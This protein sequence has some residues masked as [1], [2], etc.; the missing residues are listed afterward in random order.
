M[1]LGLDGTLTDTRLYDPADS[2]RDQGRHGLLELHAA[3]G[4]RL[5]LGLP[6]LGAGEQ[7]VEGAHDGGRVLLEVVHD[8]VRAGIERVG[9][10]R[11]AGGGVDG[12]DGAHGGPRDVVHVV[13]GRVGVGTGGV[14]RVGVLHGDLGELG[15]VPRRH[16]LLHELHVLGHD[17]GDALLEEIGRRHRLLHARRRADALLGGRGDEH[18]RPHLG[19]VRR[20]GHLHGLGVEAVGL[21]PHLPRHVPAEQAAAGGAAAL[22]RDQGEL[23]GRVG[24]LVEI[25]DGAHEGGEAGGG[26]GQ[27]GGSGE[28]VLGDDAQREG[29]ELGQRGVLLLEGGPQRP[30]LAQTRLGPGARDVGGR[31]VERQAVLARVGARAGGGG[32]RPQI[33]LRQGHGE[34]RVGGQVELRISLAPVLDDGDVD[35]RRRARAVDL[36]HGVPCSLF[37]SLILA[38]L[39]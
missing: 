8:A 4:V 1:L 23:G 38:S 37:A 6:P 29:R 11:L 28:V 5:G 30:Q 22:A 3:G 20:R 17:V 39:F 25:G 10:D 15:K 33:G 16:G 2:A 18:Q 26:R 14:E 27:A 32:Q 19:P 7:G 31:A 21:R 13:D 9:G 24:Q 34:R 35:G 36:G 12:L